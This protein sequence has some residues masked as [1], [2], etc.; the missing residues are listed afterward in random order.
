MTF[1]IVLLGL[2]GLVFV[3]HM[4]H[5]RYKPRRLS[6]ARFAR[7]LPKATQS[8]QRRWRPGNPL[9]SRPLYLQLLFIVLLI[10]ALLATFV[11]GCNGRQTASDKGIGVWVFLDTSASMSTQQGEVDRMSF[12]HQ[13]LAEGIEQMQAVGT[14]LDVCFRWT[15]FDLALAEWSDMD[16]LKAAAPRPL[17]TNTGLIQEAVNGLQTAVSPPAACS[18]T[19][20]LVIS[21]APK[22]LWLDGMDADIPIIWQDISTP[23][24]NWGFED[25]Y[26]RN[27]LT[28]A[29]NDVTVEIAIY[30]APPDNL[31][32]ALTILS[33]TGETIEPEWEASQ[34][35]TRRA[36]FMPEQAGAYELNIVPGG[37]YAYDD[38]AVI[39]VQKTDQMRVDWQLPDA[40]LPQMMGWHIT[41]DTPS[42]RVVPVGAV[43]EDEVPTLVVGA[44]YEL[45]ANTPTPAAINY[46]VEG[47]LLL[48]DVNLDAA[49][50]LGLSGP[51]TLPGFSEV[52]KSENGG[53]W[54]AQ[55]REPLA[56]Y[57]PGLPQLRDDN[58]GR[59]SM[60][61]FLNAVRWLSQSQP[62]A[63][64]Y[65]LTSLNSPEAAPG[66]LPLHPGE[67]NTSKEP[68]SYLEITD[69]QPTVTVT[70]EE[71][72]WHYFLATAALLF[73]VERGLAALGKEQWH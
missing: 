55:R 16:S 38:T 28:S 49:E 32:N 44:S 14:G 8:K 5:P 66:R 70:R 37:A 21:D 17:G 4:A 62:P 51:Q 59:F 34:G 60:L 24:D 61:V 43:P 2:A 71:P 50:T 72:I 33:P 64:L 36:R 22:P 42:L 65:E 15:T 69:I 20:I 35:S 57:I 7:D 26:A 39:L 10:G 6:S 47:S 52:L 31:E 13:K 58:L 48:A 1:V 56:A 27:P 3:I 40:A 19:H 53:I 67:G 18:I 46:F 54:L 30:G 23:V 45:L 63:P 12:A 9:R 11:A 25:I 41:S 68:A 73:L 29:T